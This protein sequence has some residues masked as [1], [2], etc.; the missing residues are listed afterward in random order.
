M[1]TVDAYYTAELA[2]ATYDQLAAT[3]GTAVAGDVAFYKSCGRRFGEPVL[4]LGGLRVFRVR[5]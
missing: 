1:T 3:S 2:V 4:E 5:H